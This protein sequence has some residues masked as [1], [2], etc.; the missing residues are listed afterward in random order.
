MH[1]RFI[2]LLSVLWIPVMANAAGTRPVLTLSDARQVIAAAVAYAH[3][4]QAPGAAV[5][6]VDD[7]GSVV[8]LE[9]LDGTFPSGP[10]VS[11]GKA[12]TAAGFKRATREIENAINKGR[13]T[14]TALPAVTT[15]TP[16][17]GG[18]PLSVGGQIVGAVGVSGATS[19]QQDDEIA[20]AAADAFA[21]AGTKT[22]TDAKRAEVRYVP[23][24]NVQR[25]LD[26]G[27]ALFTTDEF[28]VNASR[29]DMPGEAEVH[30]RDT[31]IIYVLGGKAA[32]VTGGE[33]IDPVANSADELRGR[34]I[35][36][37]TEIQ[38]SKGDVITV[39]SG[40]PHWFKQVQAPFTYYVVKTIRRGD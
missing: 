1:N 23:A 27:A 31:D 39:P 11:I 34:A 8:A 3:A 21:A 17:Q 35:R 5:A 28:K 33:V 7:G 30:L 40:V 2:A 18:V 36:G 32:L 16:L 15:F 25:A 24:P 20:Q 13:V 38:L 14:M 29:R 10:N 4:H 37:G 6:V 9:R 19:A 26:T 22:A 12:R